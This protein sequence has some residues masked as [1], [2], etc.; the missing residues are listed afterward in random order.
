MP[1]CSRVLPV[2]FML[3][4]SSVVASFAHAEQ[5]PEALRFSI[6]TFEISGNSLIDPRAAQASVQPFTGAERNFADV[7]QARLALQALYEQAGFGAVQVT[8]PEQEIT[9]GVIRFKVI[10]ARLTGIDIQTTPY[11]DRENILA[12]IPQLREGRS[13]NTRALARSLALSNESTVKQT[14]VTLNT[15]AQPG[16]IDAKVTIKDASPWRGFVSAENNGSETAGGDWRISAGLSHGN[17]FNRDHLWAMQ[18]ITSAEKPQDVQIFGGY[19]KMPLP[20]WGDAIELSGSYANVSGNITAAGGSLA[21]QAAG[22]SAGA[23]YVHNLEPIGDYKHNLSLGQDY[24][25]VE[26][27]QKFT[28]DYLLT[29]TSIAYGGSRLTQQSNTRFALSVVRNLGL[30]DRGSDANIA[31]NGG[32]DKDYG[33]IRLSLSHNLFMKGGWDALFSVNGQW[34]G[35]PLPGAEDFGVGGAGS[36][37]GFEEREIAGDKGARMGVEITT[38]SLF[39]LSGASLRLAGFV[40][41][42]QVWDDGVDPNI[43]VASTGLGIRLRIADSALLKVDAAYVFD[44]GGV[45]GEE[46][47]RIHASLVWGF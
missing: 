21:Y 4:A 31:A 32:R 10:E 44:G 5:A 47:G 41:Y 1:T 23:R 46:L 14:L 29:P 11:H 38:P 28:P 27:E 20:S 7:E 15:G 17:V 40:D 42:G 19:W 43:A 6:Q 3:M 18:A 36:V 37:R 33:L 30:G 2:A 8:V 26:T 24:R 9:S 39:K 13:P 12:S 25:L 16:E 22:Y 35:E 45:R 34:T